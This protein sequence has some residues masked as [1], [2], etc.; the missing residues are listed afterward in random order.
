MNIKA[1]TIE[2]SLLTIDQNELDALKSSLRGELILPTDARYAENCQI[3]NA[4][5][6]RKPAMIVQCQGTV[7]VLK[8][9]QFA[10]KKHFLLSVRGG[11]HNVAGRCIYNDVMLI[12]LSKM[13]SVLL[14]PENSIAIVEAGA[15]L[16][17]VDHETLNYG[18]ALP[19]GINSTT[20]I[21]GLTLGGGFGWL[22][23]KYGMTI[24][25]LISA[26]LV[27]VQGERILCDKKN[28]P[29]LFWAIRGGGGNFGIITSFTF[30]LS[31]VGPEVIAGPIVFKIEDAKEVLKNYRDFCKASPE[32]LSTWAILR[33]APP[34]PFLDPIYHGKPVLILATV[35]TGSIEGSKSLLTK[36]RGLG[37][38][39]GDGIG[40]QLFTGFQRAFDPLLTPGFRNYWK[41]QNF[42]S[43]SDGLFDAI[44]QYANKLPSP[45]TEIFIGQM[46]GAT[47]RIPIE[48]TA[49]PHREIEFI[50]NVHTRWEQPK[51][52][53][54]CISWARDFFKATNSFAAEGVY[55]NFVSEG[56]D[57]TQEAFSKNLTRLRSI[58][59]KYDPENVLRSNLNILPS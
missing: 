18:L 48:A 7:D 35:Y 6:T 38:S 42:K 39:I 40:Q 36:L 19:V 37:N 9:V 2:G 10:K 52:D 32:D 46:G 41:S 56:D 58:K 26:E 22:S 45:H 54:K 29:D 15:T 11:G 24:D 20:G 1:K 43:L 5:I 30:N 17:D 25:H 23:R 14:K 31:P 21:A 55:A 8:A 4:M 59:T 44:I 51:D 16:S 3:W 13:R 53:E 12:D 49:Y 28:H 33:C 57:N 27:T 50:M 34:F 47:N